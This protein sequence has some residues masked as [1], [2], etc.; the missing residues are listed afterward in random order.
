MNRSK[1]P[2]EVQYEIKRYQYSSAIDSGISIV[3]SITNAT[4]VYFISE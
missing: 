1:L 3:S 2:V 4:W